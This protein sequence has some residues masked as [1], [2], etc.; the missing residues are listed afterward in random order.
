[1]V[2]HMET[3]MT[4]H[5]TAATREERKPRPRLPIVLKPDDLPDDALVDKG[6]RKALTGLGDSWSYELTQ[7][8]RFP[9]PIKLGPRCA[10]WRMGELRR[11]LSDPLGYRY[12]QQ[13]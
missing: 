2:H 13:G 5:P 8:G 7:Q 6:V 3:A 1:M 12:P 11:W 10:R 4:Q 9:P